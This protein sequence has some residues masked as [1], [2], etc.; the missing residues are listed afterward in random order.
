MKTEQKTEYAIEREKKIA[1]RKAKNEQFIKDLTSYFDPNSEDDI[2]FEFCRALEALNSEV[3]NSNRKFYRQLESYCLFPESYQ[4]LEC[5]TVGIDERLSQYTE[6]S[7]ESIKTMT[8][9]EKAMHLI[10]NRWFGKDGNSFFTEHMINI[11][12]QYVCGSCEDS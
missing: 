6:Y 2:T 12:S 4:D 10:F 1:I 11:A 7:N 9:Y 8:P 5:L 3:N